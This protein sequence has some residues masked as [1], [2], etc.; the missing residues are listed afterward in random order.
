MLPLPGTIAVPPL[1]GET[2]LLME[3][4]NTSPVTAAKVKIWTDHDPILSRVKQMILQGWQKVTETAFQPYLQR[5][6]ELT[7]QDDCILW[8]SPVIIPE[9]GRERV[10][11]L[12]HEGHPGMTRM[13]AIA[14]GNVWC[15]GSDAEIERKVRE[16]NKC[17][18]HQKSQSLAHL[19]P[20]EWPNRTWTRLHID[21]AGPF[22]GRLFLITIDSHS[23][24]LD[25]VPVSSANSATTICELRKLFANLGISEIIVSDDG[26]AFTSAEFSKFTERNGIRHIRTAPYHPATLMDWLNVLYKC[27]NQL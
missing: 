11:Q 12:L 10:M 5:D 6:R 17:Q 9:E 26:T 18:M 14:Q 16:C 23:K 21:F 4:L 24:W 2:I 25:V 19:H 27:S 13:K 3:A 15:P 20:W 1:P 22:E 8:G 7:V